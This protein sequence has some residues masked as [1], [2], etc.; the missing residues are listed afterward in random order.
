MGDVPTFIMERY[1]SNGEGRDRA[2]LCSFVE[3]V[4]CTNAIQHLFHYDSIKNQ[5]QLIHTMKLPYLC[6][7]ISFRISWKGAQFIINKIIR[8]CPRARFI[9]AHTC[10]ER[11]RAKKIKTNCHKNNELKD[12]IFV[13]LN[14]T[15]HSGNRRVNRLMKNSY[16]LLNRFW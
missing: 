14:I 11:L 1:V 16:E 9:N 13:F 15:A 10:K 8:F 12:V 3:M 2:S 7:V 4:F 5:P 6:P